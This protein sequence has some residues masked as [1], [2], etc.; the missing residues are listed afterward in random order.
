MKIRTSQTGTTL[1]EALIT[2]TIFTMLLSTAVAILLTSTESWDMNSVR[3]EL[4]Q[5]QRK[6]IE[7]MKSDLMQGGYS[8]ITNVP[9]DGASYTTITFRT[10]NGIGSGAISW[11]SSTI[12]FVLS[13]TNLQRVSSSTK[14]IALDI[15]SLNF[16]R[17]SST[18][19]V[20]EVSLTAQKTTLRGRSVSISSSFKVDMRN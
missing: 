7:W 3:A 11:S 14:V 10:S 5:E 6:A 13:G 2:V 8:T 4:M 16:T 12:Q 15:S 18:P 1:V 19:S 9:A 20:V 17:Q